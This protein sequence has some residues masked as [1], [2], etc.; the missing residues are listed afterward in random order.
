MSLFVPP[1]DVIVQRHNSCHGYLPSNKKNPKGGG[2]GDR[3]TVHEV[4]H[5]VDGGGDGHEVYGYGACACGDVG[6]YS[7]VSVTFFLRQV[8]RMRA[9]G[10]SWN[11]L[12][13][14]YFYRY[15]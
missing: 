6:R 4:V 13:E 12:T 2:E 15:L 8:K 1:S 7:D 10:V 11:L 3:Y 9:C 14:R 5:E